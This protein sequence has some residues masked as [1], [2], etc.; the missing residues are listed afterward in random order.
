ML[1]PQKKEN[2]GVSPDNKDSRAATGNTES[3]VGPPVISLPKGGGAIRG[4]GEK[5]AAN[6]VTG[7]G[8]LTVPVFT[9]PGR[10]GF[11][12]QLSLSYDS[13]AGNGPFGFGW[14]LSLPQISRKTDKGLPRYHDADE[15]DV[16]ILSGAED[17]VPVLEVNQGTWTR[18]TLVRSL[19]NASYSVQRYRPRVEG[20]FARIERW[21]NQNDPADSFWRTI[22]KDNITTWYGRTQ[23]SRIADPSDATRIFSW[24]ICESY[25]DKGNAMLYRYKP[26]DTVDVDLTQVNERNRTVLS[27]SSN[28]YLKRISYGN[29]TPR[30][31]NE[32]LTQR[33]DWL[34]E[35]VFDYGE[36][37]A[38]IPAPDDAGAWICRH[39]P[40][41]SYRSGFEVRTYRLCQ[42]V[43]MFH[44]F[45]QEQGVGNDCLV[46][47]TDFVYGDTRNNPADQRRGNPT[48]SFIA[49]I[50]QTGYTRQPNG[51][52]LSK[53]LPPL[54]CEYTQAI[55]N[56]EVH[57]VDEQSLEN[58]PYGLDGSK[59]EWIDLDGEGAPGI[60]TRQAG[61]WFYKRNLSPLS[62]GERSNATFAPVELVTSLPSLAAT[63]GRQQFLDLSGDGQID[64]VQLESPTAGFYERTND[65][66]WSPFVAFESFTN[67]DW[68]SP[69]LKFVDLTGD[70]Y[71]DI[72]ISEDDVFIWHESLAERGFA[73]A[74]R[75]QQALEEEA[76]PRLVFADGTQ[77]IYLADFSGDGLTDLVRIRNGEVCYWPNL[78]Y[79]RFGA[80]VTMD[81]A[82]WFDAPDLFEQQRIRLADIDGSG[83]T[84]IIYLDHDGVDLYFNR[85]GNSWSERRTLE[86]F[87]Q[88]DNISAVTVTDLLGNGTAC[89]VWSS[90]LPVNAGRQIRYIDLMGGLKPHLLVR[91]FNNLGAETHIS[92]APSTRFYVQDKLNG[93]PWITRI[94]FPVHVVERVETYDY[95]S[96]NRFVSRY[97]YHHGYFDAEEREFRGFGM[98][99]QWDTEE[100]AA[101]DTNQQLPVAN[102]DQSS[103]VPP[104][105]TRTW[106]HSGV[107][108]DRNHVSDFF[109][110]LIDSNDRGEY[111][112]E[113]GL[114]DQQAR[115]LLLDDTVLG[116][117]WTTEEEREA[118]RAL[119]GSML[120]QEVYALDGSE[121]EPHPYT[122][123]EQ[124]FTIRRLQPRAGNRH[125]VFFTHA[126][127]VV[128]YHYERNPAD[129]RTSH[130]LTLEVD[131]F[132]NALKSVAVGYSRRHAD[133]A[134]ST[135]EAAKQT[136]TLLVYTENRFTNSIDLADDYRTPLPA[137]TSTFELTGYVPFAANGRFEIADF[138]LFE[139]A[140]LRFNSEINFESAPTAGRQRRL[141]E[142]QRTYYRRDDLS[143]R[144]P[145]GQVQPLALPFDS[146]KLAFTPGLLTNVY[147]RQSVNLLPNAASVLGG[148]G[149]DG[150]GYVD[151]DGDG[152]WWVLSGRMFYAPGNTTPAVE[153]AEARQHFFLPRVFSD[154]FGNSVSIDYQ[155]DLLL[156]RVRDPLNNTVDASNDYRVLQPRLVT[157]A[158]GNR[159]EVS[160]DALGMVAGT[161]LMGKTTENL[162]DSLAGFQADLS[163]AQVDNF[164]AAVDPHVPATALLGSATTRTVYDLDRFRTSRL[165]H[166]DDPTQWLPAYTAT[167]ARETHTSDSLPAHGL[168]I[169]I[170]FSYSDGFGREIQ[171]KMQAE[172]GPLTEGGPILNPR[173]VSTGWTIVNNK[174]KP[175]RDFEPFFSHLGHHF[176]FGVQNGVSPIVFYDPLGRA[177]VTL[178]PN[179]TYEKVL[180]DPWQQTIWDVNDTALLDPRTDPDVSGFVAGL[181]LPPTW[182]TWHQQRNT[183]TLGVN[184]HAAAQKTA[185]HA[186]TPTVVH[187]DILGRTFLTVTDNGPDSNL[188]PQRYRTRVNLDIKSNQREIVDAR[189]RAVV[190]YDYDLLDTVIHVAGMEAGEGWLLNDVMKQAIRNWDS[191]GHELRSE[192]D[193]LRRNVRRFVR[194]TDATNSDPR[195]LNQEVLFERVEYGENQPNAGALNLR[196][197]V[198]RQDDGAGVV[199]N[200]SFD[201][202]GNPLGVSRQ[203]TQD[204]TAL[205]N[206]STAVALEASVY[207]TSTIYDA[208]NRFLT[209]TTPDASTIRLTYNEANLLDHVDVNLRGE[210][211]NGQPVFTTFVSNI[212]YNARAQRTRINY[213]NGVETQ[214]HYDAETFRLTHLYTRRGA[215]FTQDCGND[216]AAPFS[217][218]D[219]PPVG[220]RC[221]LQN[222]HYTYDPAG[223]ITHIEDVAQQ[224]VYFR[225]HR[226]E[227]HANYTYDP[228][229]RLIEAT[230]REHLA[231]TAAGP[232]APFP[233]S[234][235]D[236]QP[237]LNPGDGNAMGTYREQYRYDEVGNILEMIH[238]GTDPQ[239]PGWT[240]TYR[241]L[242]NSL[243][244]PGRQSNRLTGTTIGNTPENYSVNG[245]GYDLHGNMLHMPH[246]QLMLWDFKDQLRLTRRQAVNPGDEDGLQ[247]QGERT[248]Y[249]YDSGGQRVRKVTELASGQLKDERIYLGG[250]EIYRRAGVNAVVRETLHIMDD[251]QRIALVETRTSGNDGSP[252]RLLRYQ[253]S[254]HLGSAN[255]ELDDQARIVSYE[256]HFPF[257]STSYR[258]QD[259]EVNAK[260]YRYGGKER[261]EESQFYYYGMRYYASWLGRWTAADP[262]GYVDGPNLYAFTSNNPT[263]KI[264]V[265]GMQ[266]EEN[267]FYQ[268]T[269]IYEEEPTGPLPEGTHVFPFPSKDQP[270]LWLWIRIGPNGAQSASTFAFLPTDEEE[271]LRRVNGDEDVARLLVES[272]KQYNLLLARLIEQGRDPVDVRR[273]EAEVY[274]G[275]AF[276]EGLL[277]GDGEISF[278]QLIQLLPLA[279]ILRRN[280]RT[281]TRV[282]RPVTITSETVLRL[283]PKTKLPVQLGSG[284]SVGPAYRTLADAEA[285]N[286]GTH[287]A[288]VIVRK[289]GRELAR[290]WE[291]SEGGHSTTNRRIGDTEQKALSRIRLRRDVEVEIRGTHPPCNE[292]GGC[293]QTMRAL[294]EQVE[295]AQITYRAVY[296]TKNGKLVQQVHYYSKGFEPPTKD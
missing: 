222:L 100:F 70:G 269:T 196:T 51:S 122:V 22:S 186:A 171:K 59:Y 21:T 296:V 29:L 163:S 126:R 69:N 32:E 91:S 146:Y 89:L 20:L 249:L 181:N 25:D 6:P 55:V 157:D 234:H 50:T 273:A 187:F 182:Q 129:P 133:P 105:L 10:S 12:P 179:R 221:G 231:Q 71:A 224:T 28:R 206:W 137:E 170:S 178:H 261:D 135:I 268:Q 31:A 258:S 209:V 24:L 141:I 217:S 3:N 127:E 282:P 271:I 98:V 158:N 117:G 8:T 99:E 136:T 144:L 286:I 183:G 290:W 173:W 202:K 214:Y 87:P 152:H 49:S 204:Y 197:R 58:L 1:N 161:A 174:G 223:N 240:R 275:K 256:E 93:R 243:L 103:H 123:T 184:E 252:A 94:A 150:G 219:Q 108:I 84:D 114:T 7:T 67:L 79:G 38:Q 132:G 257:G 13:G 56:E 232:L 201:F 104:V 238:L 235:I 264:D 216:P 255:L 119:K 102:V 97:A 248:F 62:Q 283:D 294:T 109:A 11:G 281:P 106:F 140:P 263:S 191:R 285:A 124:N 130:A 52:Y 230:G 247:R 101:L 125:A 64:L 236:R 110:G 139:G 279:I 293:M 242:E 92:Y 27:R 168:R 77:S 145:L 46:R 244:Q 190:R 156:V 180:F 270:D 120:R 272:A 48:G 115:Q 151:L 241:Y 251:K 82:P 185:T 211:V 267:E 95:I 41:S 284:E 134:L 220:V 226:V 160:L 218:P 83:V 65:Q 19:N 200:Q 177:V 61:G 212:D 169:Q 88:V 30:Q 80:R 78:G 39:D 289:D 73:P 205:P 287:Y 90:A 118:C 188:N 47:S 164:F 60:L 138:V 16:F 72:L 45:P 57:E 189:D 40:I 213:G 154:P 111:Y 225:N 227:P 167:L 26:E 54:E 159:T 153:L 96:R 280:L 142:R 233:P 37:D 147:Q 66:D 131:D 4:I 208:L 198:F 262:A 228:L 266:T 193:S 274:L 68:D 166:P 17:L 175:V 44:H 259:A 210:Q 14:Q 254:N 207:T 23:A 192:Y 9:S 194:G 2:N 162:G 288:E 86:C 113:P 265:A 63:G 128:N 36:H 18:P 43:L 246:L 250:F 155:Y 143:A 148:N 278:L 195:T 42:R 239:Q 260:R 172:P 291:A 253:F 35:V 81:H 15:S 76:G 215:T 149:S 276:A 33:S 85:S 245:D 229:Y 121:K 199:T 74:E 165:A 277:G 53:S 176:E 292:P 237:V 5:F 34:F 116:E 203:I 107:F 75:V 295:G 112:R